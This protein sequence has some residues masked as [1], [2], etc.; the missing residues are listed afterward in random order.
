MHF[1]RLA[2]TVLKDEESVRDNHV[3]ARILPNIYQFKKITDRLSNN[4]FLIWLL[5]TPPQLQYVAT[6]HC[7]LSL[8]A[9]FVDINV[10]QG[11]VTTYKRCCGTP[12]RYSLSSYFPA[13]AGKVMRSVVSAYIHRSVFTSSLNKLTSGI[14]FFARV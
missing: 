10:S 13:L 3:L 6:L 14:A 4:P 1:A 12:L 11:S 2:N 9:C 5:K 7:N 8:M